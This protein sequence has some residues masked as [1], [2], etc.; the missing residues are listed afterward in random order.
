MKVINGENLILG[1][2]ASQV[3]KAALS[4][5]EIALVNCEKLMVTGNKDSILSRQRMLADLK[6]KP[7]KGRFYETRPDFFVQRAIQNMLPKSNRGN[8][9]LSRIRCH[10]SVPERLKATATE[11]FENAHV[12]KVPNLKYTT[13]AEICKHMGGK[14]QQ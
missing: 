3:A 12:N 6:G 11:A 8:V 2:V 5:E 14:W 9:A 7:T 10:I 13:I 4:G 1:R